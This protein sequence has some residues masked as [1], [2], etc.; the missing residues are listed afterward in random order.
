MLRS[1]E[2][3]VW[4]YSGRVGVATLLKKAASTSSAMAFE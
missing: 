1:L 2:S 3:S 4:K